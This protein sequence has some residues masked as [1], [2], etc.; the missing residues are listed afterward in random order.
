MAWSFIN[1]K[2]LSYRLMAMVLFETLPL[3]RCPPHKIL[4]QWKSCTALKLLLLPCLCFKKRKAEF[5]KK[6]LS[7]ESFCKSSAISSTLNNCSEEFL[8]HLSFFTVVLHLQNQTFLDGR[9]PLHS[10]KK[11]K[12]MS[13]CAT[14]WRAG[15]CYTDC[16]QIYSST[17][18]DDL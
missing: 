16:L 2:C 11:Q 1:L 9:R 7:S 17:K 12:V 6:M 18:L 3:I 10:Y 15:H 14:G 13:Q 5:P 4:N 8:M